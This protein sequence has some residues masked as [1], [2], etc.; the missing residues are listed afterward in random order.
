MTPFEIWQDPETKVTFYFSHS[1][2]NLTTGVM[3][4]PPKT[5]LP[6]HNRPKAFENLVQISG[7]CLMKVFNDDGSV[8]EHSLEAG[9]KLRMAKGQYHIHSNP[10]EDTSYTLFKAEGDITEV[11]KVLRENFRRLDNE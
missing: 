4:I 3:V 9:E 10:F 2:E 6:K 8:T 5:E 11:M 1:D 7:Q